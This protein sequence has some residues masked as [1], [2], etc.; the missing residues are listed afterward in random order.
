MA[1]TRYDHLTQLGQAT[2][3]PKSPE[4]AMNAFVEAVCV[5]LRDSFVPTQDTQGIRKI[6]EIECVLDDCS[7]EE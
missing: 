2:E 4:E 5:G 7:F 1:G 6:V 3:M